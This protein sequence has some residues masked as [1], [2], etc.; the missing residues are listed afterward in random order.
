[1][2]DYPYKHFSRYYNLGY[3]LFLLA[4][5]HSFWI[6][7]VKLIQTNAFELKHF[8]LLE[9]YSIFLSRFLLFWKESF[10]WIC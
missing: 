5:G 8:Y 4:L 7:N 2:F 9:L 1:M 6:V 10:P 3:G